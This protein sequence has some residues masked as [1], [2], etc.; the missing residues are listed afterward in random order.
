MSKLLINNRNGYQEIIDV[1][2]GGSYFDPS[3]ILWDERVDGALP[4]ITLGGMVRNGDV[5]EFDQATA[6]ASFIAE[7]TVVV[8]K[9]HAEIDAIRDSKI[10]EGVPYT[11]PDGINGTIQ[12]RDLKDIINV[13]GTT[14]AGII[15]KLLGQDTA[16][17]PFKDE[18]NVDHSFS[19][20]EAMTMGMSALSGYTANYLAAWE[21]KR[22]IK[23]LVDG[24]A[25]IAQ[26]EAYDVTTGWP[27]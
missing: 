9:K 2:E 6:D 13:L 21:H 8:I 19:P 16:V 24:G 17:L 27:E 10:P 4:E 14:V 5:L 12:M 22:R 25:T 1:C 3:A 18:E 23:A 7:I 11:F 15:Y 26:I 20:V